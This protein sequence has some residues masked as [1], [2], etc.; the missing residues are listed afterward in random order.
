MQTTNQSGQRET[1]KNGQKLKTRKK[2]KPHITGKMTRKKRNGNFK[3]APTYS[4][5]QRK[6]HKRQKSTIKDKILKILETEVNLD[7]R[8]IFGKLKAGQPSMKRA[9]VSNALTI[10]KRSGELLCEKPNKVETFR[11]PKD[12]DQNK[13]EAEDIS[14]NNFSEKCKKQE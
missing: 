12:R 14:T 13:Q 6:R 11:L 9:S 7:R 2:P 8:E 3:A 1:V 5:N 4:K 10:L